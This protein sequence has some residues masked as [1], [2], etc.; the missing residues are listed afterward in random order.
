MIKHRNLRSFFNGVS[1]LDC[2]TTW[3]PIKC[4]RIFS[5]MPV[6]CV[7]I[8]F[9][10]KGVV[11]DLGAVFRSFWTILTSLREAKINTGSPCKK[12]LYCVISLN[13]YFRKLWRN[14]SHGSSAYVNINKVYFSWAKINIRYELI[15]VKIVLIQRH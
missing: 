11:S 13:N 14:N 1:V 15:S 6:K 8:A 12:L 5:R 10:T 4:Q 2:V 3:D 7:K 9:L